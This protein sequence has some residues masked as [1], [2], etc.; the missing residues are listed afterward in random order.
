MSQVTWRAPD[1]L[2]KRVQHLAGAEGLSM[3]EFLTRVLTL[4]SDADETDPLAV[5]LRNRLRSAGMLADGST[6]ATRPSADAL[7]RARAAAGAGIPLSEVVSTLR[8]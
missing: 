2:V 7:A 8:S 6:T 4:A 1:A 3:N 5:R